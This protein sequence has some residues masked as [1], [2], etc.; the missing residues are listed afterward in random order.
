MSQ[1]RPRNLPEPSGPLAK[2]A[3]GIWEEGGGGFARS[4]PAP[5][6]PP[7]SFKTHPAPPGRFLTSRW[8]RP[9][10]HHPS[11]MAELAPPP[12]QPMGGRRRGMRVESGGGGMVE[13]GGAPARARPPYSEIIH[14]G[15]KKNN[16]SIYSSS[17]PPP[18][19]FYNFNGLAPKGAGARGL[20]SPAVP[21]LCA[22]SKSQVFNLFLLIFLSYYF[23]FF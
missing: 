9:L 23:F 8:L 22:A 2:D 11:P 21:S 4:R 14:T 19:S 5:R 15:I 6:P 7:R 13:R 12:R 3:R 1:Q 18:L 20:C 17:P 10:R 16:N